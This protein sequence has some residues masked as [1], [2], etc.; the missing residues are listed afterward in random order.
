MIQINKMAVYLS[1]TIAA[2]SNLNRLHIS[3]WIVMY[4]I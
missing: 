3:K 2:A 4:D 1:L